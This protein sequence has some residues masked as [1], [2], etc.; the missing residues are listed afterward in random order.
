MVGGLVDGHERFGDHGRQHE[1]GMDLAVVAGARRLH[2]CLGQTG[3]VGLTL[4]S[5]GIELGRDD[6]RRRGAG[7]HV[8]GGEHG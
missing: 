8:E 7:Q 6:Q 2:P 1:E 4:V 3:G 5:Q